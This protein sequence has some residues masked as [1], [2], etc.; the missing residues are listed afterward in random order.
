ML[1]DWFIGGTIAVIALFDVYLL[2]AHR[3]T[4]SRR[5]RK[6]G[7]NIVAMP[8]A[9]GVLGGHFWGPDGVDPAL[10]G[11]GPSVGLLVAVGATLV[12]VH[13]LVRRW[14]KLPTWWP[15]IYLVCGIP[16][17]IWLWPQ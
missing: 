12:G 9:W 7:R 5:M 17:G 6:H 14:L 16:C 11:Y 3:K 2:L 13:L 15:L 10:G 1:T 4:I 8:W